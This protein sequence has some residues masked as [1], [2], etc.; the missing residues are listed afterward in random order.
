MHNPLD[1]LKRARTQNLAQW[2]PGPNIFNLEFRSLARPGHGYG[3]AC[4]D[5]EGCILHREPPTWGNL[6]GRK[7]K[8]LK[9]WN[10]R[11]IHI[12]YASTRPVGFWSMMAQ[13]TRGVIYPYPYHGLKHCTV[14]IWNLYKRY[15]HL[16]IHYLHE[17]Q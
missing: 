11:A 5:C 17:V 10:S 1:Q 9:N 6:R 7:R 14:G 8:Y 2:R 15:F 4:R 13:H 16:S 3:P 12:V